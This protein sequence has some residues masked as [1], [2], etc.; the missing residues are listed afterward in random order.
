MT[1][2]TGIT[3]GPEWLRHARHKGE[4]VGYAGPNQLLEA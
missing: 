2:G 1:E 4:E 3:A